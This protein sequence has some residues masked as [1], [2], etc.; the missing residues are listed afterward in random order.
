MTKRKLTE[1]ELAKANQ[2]LFD[3][4]IDTAKKLLAIGVPCGVATLGMF[5]EDDRIGFAGMFKSEDAAREALRRVVRQW[6]KRAH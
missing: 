5:P 4:S 2:I 6:A 3:A 1:A